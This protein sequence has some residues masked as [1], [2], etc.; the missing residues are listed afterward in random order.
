LDTKLNPLRAPARI[1]SSSIG[2]LVE[3]PALFTMLPREQQDKLYRA[4][5]LPAASSWLEPR[6]QHVTFSPS[7]HAV[8]ATVRGDKVH[9]QLNDGGERAVDHVLLGTGYK[10][11][12]DRYS[13]LSPELLQSVRTVKGYPVLNRG[14]ESSLPGLYFVGAPAT[15]SFGPFLRFV[16]GSQ[17]AAR[18]LSRYALRVPAART[19]DNLQ[20][21]PAAGP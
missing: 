15:Y 7:R 8:K 19:F 12:I 14:F 10:V 13:F 20:R 1:G 3:R 21:T 9:L 4:A 5:V 17:Y 16:V 18:A 11:D 6:T 2:W